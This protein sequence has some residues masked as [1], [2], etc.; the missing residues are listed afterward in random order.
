MHDGPHQASIKQVIPPILNF[1]MAAKE[2]YKD[3]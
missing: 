1:K 2:K 3:H